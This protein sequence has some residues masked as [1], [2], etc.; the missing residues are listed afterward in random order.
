MGFSPWY[1]GDRLPV[2][3]MLLEPD[4]G[5]LDASA[6]TVDDFSLVF[7]NTT[8]HAKTTGTGT[9]SNVTLASGATP[10]SVQYALSAAD[11]TLSGMQ[12]VRIVIKSGTA[13]QKTF[14]MGI[15]E[16]IS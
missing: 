12:E 14:N 8:N 10:A 3:D 7:V 4:S 6:L 5:T 9:F 13:N 15:W 11:A 1:R 16:C 2:W